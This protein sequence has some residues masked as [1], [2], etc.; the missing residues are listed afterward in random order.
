M[1]SKIRPDYGS[2]EYWD[3]GYIN[4]SNRDSYDCYFSYDTIQNGFEPFFKPLKQENILIL[5]CGL[6][7]FGQDMLDAG[8]TNVTCMDF[9]SAAIRILTQRQRPP[10]DGIARL[11]YLL[12]DVR[13][14]SAFSNESFDVVIDKGVLD[15]VVCGVSNSAGAIQM[16]DEI[17]RILV[18]DGACF[19]FSNG[20][21][22]TRAPYIDYNP[23]AWQINQITIG[24]LVRE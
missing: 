22:S 2:A 11:K 5:G 1:S 13:D 3:E 14:M 9:S 21:Y 20:T 4:G 15:S 7:T 16:M 17:H 18:P 24:I 23:T 12:M 19:I 8:F 6:S 10:V